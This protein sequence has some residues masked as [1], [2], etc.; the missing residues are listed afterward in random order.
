MAPRVDVA[1]DVRHPDVVASVRQDQRCN[2]SNNNGD[3]NNLV[4]NET[5]NFKSTLRNVSLH[6]AVI[7]SVS[8]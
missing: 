2:R 3:E 5:A 1:P 6:Q 7:L 8:P 4:S